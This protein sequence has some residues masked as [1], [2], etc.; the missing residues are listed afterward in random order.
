MSDAII[1]TVG[2]EYG[3]TVR[4]QL[5]ENKLSVSFFTAEILAQGCDQGAG[6]FRPAYMQKGASG[7]PCDNSE[8][9][10]TA[11]RYFEGFV[12]WDGCSHIEFGDD[13]DRYLHLCGRESFDK[14]GLIIAAVFER[15]GELMKTA[16]ANF[17]EG[18]FQ[19]S[20]NHSESNG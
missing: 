5:H 13:E 7:F 20:Q 1:E 6:E 19:V 10:E 16:G 3:A 9:F 18:E 4:Y 11:E 8:S 12:K 14:L 17:L 15:C 2:G